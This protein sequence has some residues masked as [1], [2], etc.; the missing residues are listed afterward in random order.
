MAP[1]FVVKADQGLPMT[2]CHREDTDAAGPVG[3]AAFD[4]A[5]RQRRMSAP[6]GGEIPQQGPHLA[7]RGTDHGAREYLGHAEPPRW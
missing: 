7:D 2:A 5:W 4:L 3:R 6:V 1:E